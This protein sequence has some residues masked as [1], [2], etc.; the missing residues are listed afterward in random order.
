MSAVGSYLKFLAGVPAFLR[1]PP[2]TVEEAKA[3]I[4]ADFARRDQ[5]FMDSL[6]HAVFGHPRSPYLPLLRMAGCELGDI[7]S[8]VSSDGIEATLHRLRAEGVYVSFEEFK[9]RRPIERS[10]R[11]FDVLP[12]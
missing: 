2:M 3:T 10:G 9:G 1:R 5:V 12:Q 8:L 4:R 7:R 11:T 6:G